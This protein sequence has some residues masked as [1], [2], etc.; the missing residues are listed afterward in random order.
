MHRKTVEIFW[1]PRGFMRQ[2]S[3]APTFRQAEDGVYLV[4][5]HMTLETATLWDWLKWKFGKRDQDY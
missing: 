2:V 5:S 1:T 4:L 3:E